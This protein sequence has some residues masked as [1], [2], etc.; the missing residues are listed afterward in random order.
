MAAEATMLEGN[1]VRLGRLL[2]VS[3]RNLGATPT[4]QALEAVAVL[5]H[6]A[7]SGRGRSFHSVRHVFDLAEG[8]NAYVALGAAFHDTVYLQVDDGL[9]GRVAEILEGS[10]ERRGDEVRLT[11]ADPRTDR[12]RAMVMDLFELPPGVPVAPTAGLNETLSAILAVRALEGLLPD[13]ALLRI[14][15]AIEATVPFQGP[16]HSERLREKVA[17]VAA[18]HAVELSEAE[19]D[20]C[21]RDAVDLAN[22][23]VANFAEA[24]PARFLDNTW[25]LLP[26]TN[27]S[28]RL[29]SVY[30][31]R[32]YRTAMQRMEGFLSTLDAG[33]VFLQHR[34]RP[35]PEAYEAMRAAAARNLAVAARYLG[36]KLVATCLLDA[37]AEL[38]G[39]DTPVA[40][41]MGDLPGEGGEEP[42][43]MER[44]LPRDEAPQMPEDEVWRLLSEG[45]PRHSGFD[46]KNA[47]LAAYLYAALW[48]LE[49]TVAASRRY[50]AG[51]LDAREYLEAFDPHVAA[52]VARASAQVAFFRQERLEALARALEGR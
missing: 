24:D 5:V 48:P 39:G 50:C 9:S 20:A 11:L 33:R 29:R 27:W 3:L 30:G 23:D 16:P 19:L 38:T 47:P 51:A 1:L 26:E 6:E 10:F 12:L 36:A 46:L 7:M 40:M 45:R 21:V 15:A 25:A 8:P 34:G 17:R 32:D 18:D 35:T 22:K 49:P 28:L 31:V 42:V 13:A 52:Q 43:R 41:L 44:F 37:L 14:A 4:P 2:S